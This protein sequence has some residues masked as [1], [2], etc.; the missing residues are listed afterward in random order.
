MTDALIYLDPD[1]GISLQ[2]QIRQKLVEAILNDT[3]PRTPPALFQ[4]A[5]PTARGRAQHR[6]PG[7]PAAGR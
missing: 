1:S 3:Y 6:G 7:L 5:G 4:K 2:S